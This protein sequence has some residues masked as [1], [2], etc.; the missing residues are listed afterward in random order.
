MIQLFL[1]HLQSELLLVFIRIP[2]LFVDEF[3]FVEVR[4]FVCLNAH[5]SQDFQVATLVR[6]ACIVQIIHHLP[7]VRVLAVCFNF[8]LRLAV[9]VYGV[10]QFLLILYGVIKLSGPFRLFRLNSILAFLLLLSRIL[11]GAF[12]ACFLFSSGL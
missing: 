7:R 11:F 6:Q 2:E 9:V 5:A 3:V 12:F 1:P 8:M 10:R 4:V